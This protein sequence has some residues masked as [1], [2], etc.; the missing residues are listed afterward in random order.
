[1]GNQR[2]V[3]TLCEAM[4]DP[5]IEIEDEKKKKKKKKIRGDKE[6]AFSRGHLYERS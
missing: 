5:G 3:F 6:D 1:M 4:M 2:T